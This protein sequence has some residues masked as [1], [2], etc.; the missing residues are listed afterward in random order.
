MSHKNLEQF[1]KKKVFVWHRPPLLLTILSLIWPQY[2]AMSLSSQSGYYSWHAN[3]VNAI[4]SWIHN[5]LK[6][7]TEYYH[8]TITTFPDLYDENLLYFSNRNFQNDIPQWQSQH[9]FVGSIWEISWSL[10]RDHEVIWALQGPV[11]SCQS[12]GSGSLLEL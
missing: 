1:W 11:S 7:N 5:I 8:S 2:N 12:A 6:Q 3:I 9:S 10:K 4:Q